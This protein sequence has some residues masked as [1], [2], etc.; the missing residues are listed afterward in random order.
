[1]TDVLIGLF[2]IGYLGA[3]IYFLQRARMYGHN[4]LGIILAFVF[5]PYAVVMGCY[6]L[7]R[8]LLFMTS[9]ESSNPDNKN[10]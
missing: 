5:S 8:D 7:V 10:I 9:S 4:S 6:W 3:L 1:M 2:S